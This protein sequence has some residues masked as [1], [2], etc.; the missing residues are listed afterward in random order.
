M[1]ERFDVVVIGS[2]TGG[3]AAAVRCAQKGASVAIVEKDTVGGTC[4]NCGCIPSKA[5]L[6]S[7]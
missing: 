1:A 4:L 7:A 6:A 3:Y 5:L 2:G